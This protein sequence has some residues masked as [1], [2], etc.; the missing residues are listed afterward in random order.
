MKTS[1]DSF[2]LMSTGAGKAEKNGFGYE[3]RV[4]KKKSK[5]EQN[6][7][8]QKMKQ[9]GRLSTGKK[10]LKFNGRKLLKKMQVDPPYTQWRLSV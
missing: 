4:Q 8:W 10:H 3:H 5:M 1:W 7:F 6:R 2:L 9:L